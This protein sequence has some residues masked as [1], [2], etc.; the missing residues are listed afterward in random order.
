MLEI[1][2]WLIIKLGILSMSLI[3]NRDPRLDY[4]RDQQTLNA[5][6]RGQCHLLSGC[7]QSVC[8]DLFANG[9]FPRPMRYAPPRARPLQQ[10]VY[11]AGFFPVPGER[12]WYENC[13][14]QK[15]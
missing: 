1:K 15:F 7:E 8:Q 4:V 9:V 12:A 10:K 14:N 2:N 6:T 13:H 5:L 3:N 11:P